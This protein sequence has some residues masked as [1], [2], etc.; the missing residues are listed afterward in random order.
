MIVQSRDFRCWSILILGLGLLIEVDRDEVLP[1][2][3]IPYLEANR[4]LELG[5]VEGQVICPISRFG[6]AGSVE[7]LGVSSC[8]YYY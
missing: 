1:H 7:N 5:D 2:L 8:V 4:G 3:A 6:Y